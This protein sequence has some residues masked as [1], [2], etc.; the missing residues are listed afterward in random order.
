MN[1]ERGASARVRFAVVLGR[2]EYSVNVISICSRVTSA[3]RQV[4][5]TTR[6]TSSGSSAQPAIGRRRARADRGSTRGGARRHR[7]VNSVQ[8]P[9]QSM[10][11]VPIVEDLVPRVH[12]SVLVHYI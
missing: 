5:P 12:D 6:T 7:T 3:A 8:I 1:T 11:N 10:M 9:L 4:A 2:A